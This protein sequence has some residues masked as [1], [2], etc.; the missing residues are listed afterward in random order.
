MY[1]SVTSLTVILGL[2]VTLG[3]C[4]KNNSTPAASPKDPNTAPAAWIDRFS[5]AAG[6]LQVRT[7]T[8]GLPGPNQPVNFDQGPFITQGLSPTGGVIW[9]YNFDLQTATPA[10]IYVFYKQSGPVTGQNNVV[11][12]TPGVAGYNDFWLINKVTVPDNYVANSVTSYQEIMAAGYTITPTS[13]LV[14]CPVVPKGSTATKRL[15]AGSD[16]GLEV[17]WYKD[18]VIYYFNFAEKS[19]TTNA[20]N[21]VPVIPIFVSFNINPNEPNGGPASGFKT[22]PGTTQTHNVITALPSDSY[23]TPLWA[24]A[25]YDNNSFNSVTNA[26]TAAAAPLLVPNAG[27]V[28]C[29]VV[30]IQ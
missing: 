9:Y 30:A 11:D 6:H 7:S 1:K 8:N 13:Q 27:N 28:N 22:E 29:P 2:A 19:I 12:V 16:A 21:Q 17:G 4:K 26:T 3:S 5:S 14:N 24:V 20:N 25:V 23:Y 18:S 15:P 10:P